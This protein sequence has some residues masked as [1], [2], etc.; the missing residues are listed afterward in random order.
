MIKALAEQR[1]LLKLEY[2]A[3]R[4][5]FRRE[6]RL[7]GIDRKVKRGLCWYPVSLGRSYYNSLNRQVVEVLR[8]DE[9]DAEHSFEY[10]RSVVFFTQDA[11]GGL[12]Y[13]PF[14]CT[15]SYVDGGRMVVDLGDE[16]ALPQLMAA[17]RLGVQL[18]FDEKTYRLM[19]AALDAVATAKEG[20][21][22]EL[23]DL[24]YSPAEPRKGGPLRVQSPWLNGAQQA[25]VAEVV[26]AKD[27]AIVHGPP[28]TGKT[29]TLVEAVCEVLRRETQVLVCAQSNM[30]VDWISE[31]LVDRGVS[32]L[33]MGN[34][35]RVND[36][37]LGFTYER[38]FEAHPLYP[39][40]WAAR[41]TI[42]QLRQGRADEQRHQKIARL[43]ERADELEWQIHHAL[44]DGA[45]VIACTLAGSAG[46][47][48]EGM[49]FH[50][51]FVD[52]AAQAL[53]AATW[54]A[55]ARADR[56]VLA[57]DHCQLPPTVKSREALQGGLGITLME[58]LAHSKP[59]CVSL[60]TMQYR[61]NE[62]LMRFSNEWFYGGRVQSAP[63]VRHR[64]LLDFDLPLVW[65]DTS[66]L[67]MKEEFV[68]TNYGRINRGEAQLTVAT[69]QGYIERIG[70]QRFKDE[71]IDVGLISPYRAQVQLL[72][73]MFAENSFF[74]PLRSRIS[75]NTVDGFQGQERDVIVISLVRANDEGQIGFLSDLRRM[76]VAMTRAR[77]KLIILG[78]VAT[79]TARHPFY[80]KLYAYAE[81]L[82]RE[83]MER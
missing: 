63:S 79:L 42:R 18:S 35:T 66:G 55:I 32:V 60:L 33:R 6:T 7:M 69:L 24:F 54:I 61:M 68:G 62:D 23:R 1:R 77:M 73:H 43:R 11:T 76:N 81:Q 34:P 39:E 26:R 21:L 20:R 82:R 12:F 64:G 51:L 72:R 71:N 10:G 65:Q 45:R 13:F 30:A 16:R 78:E 38:R 36:K 75:V 50:T 28:G 74:K 8:G 44:M 15:V 49:H 27:V 46:R 4:E 52:E 40:L 25:A 67:E 47:W 59:T 31:K 29:T 53:E 58:R 57:G 41:R 19:F 80:S 83:A 5:A 3:E 70:V 17:E 2:E 14:T 48:L 56:V 37:M 22:A 9:A